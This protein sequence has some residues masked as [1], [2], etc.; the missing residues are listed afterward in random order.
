MLKVKL[1]ALNHPTPDDLDV[2]DRKV[3]ASTILWLEDQKIRQYKIED[4]EKLRQVDKL[5]VWEKAYAEYKSDLGM[6]KYKTP[7]EEISWMLGYAVRLE[8]LDEPDRYAS[9]NSQE[10]GA[11]Q[12]KSIAPSIKAENFFDNMDFNNKDFIAGVRTLASK[13]QVPHHP[14]HLIQLE[15]IARL[16]KERLSPAAKNRKPIVGTPFPFEKGE[17]VVSPNDKDL[18]YPVRIMRLLQIQSLRELQT[19]IN[20]TIVA[21]QDLTANPKTD[22]KLGQVGR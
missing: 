16:V 6:P 21:V 4:R 22:T 5:P 1:Q 13:L 19:R 18:D 8:F 9:I 12:K 2:N 14:N 20:E 11:K 15:A 7:L 3:F 17:D 10:V